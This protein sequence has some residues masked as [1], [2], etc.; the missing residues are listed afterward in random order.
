MWHVTRSDREAGVYAHRCGGPGKCPGSAGREYYLRGFDGST[1]RAGDMLFER[2]PGKCDRCAENKAV[3]R[4][5]VDYL[6]EACVAASRK[7]HLVRFEVTNGSSEGVAWGH[8]ETECVY[9]SDGFCRGPERYL[10]F[11]PIE[12]RDP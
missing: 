10:G 11:G 4:A 9:G 2:S 12:R 8:P 6:C 7:W 1:W 3:T 5:G